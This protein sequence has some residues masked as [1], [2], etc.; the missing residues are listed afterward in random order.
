M[1]VIAFIDEKK[2]LAELSPGDMAGIAGMSEYSFASA[3]EKQNTMRRYGFLPGI[4]GQEINPSAI[5][6]EA[7]K[8]ISMHND[9][10][11]AADTLKKAASRFCGFFATK[12]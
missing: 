7:T 12:K 11:T 3:M 10:L 8:V 2:V 5:F 9:A 4:V 6:E 1:K